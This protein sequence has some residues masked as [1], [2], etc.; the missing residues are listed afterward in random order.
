ML[1][2]ILRRVL[3][4]V[5]VIFAVVSCSFFLVR[6]MPGNPMQV[7]Y[8]QLSKQGGMTPLEIQQHIKTIY[9]IQ[10]HGSL[11]SQYLTYVGHAAQGDLGKSILDP[12]K[13]VVSVIANALPWT[14]LIVGTS[15]L[16]SFVIGVAAG[17]VMAAFAKRA[18]GKLV[19]MVSTIFSAI[20]NYL[21]ALILIYLLTDIHHVFPTSGPYSPSVAPG[22]TAPFI[23]SVAYHAILP[24]AAATVTAFGGWALAM[25][26]S[27]VSTLGSDYIRASESWGLTRRRITQSYIGR[28]SMLPVVTSLALS[29][30]GMFGGSVFIESLFS[31]PGLGYYL[32]QSVNSR[33]YSLMMG[34]FILITITVVLSNFVVDLLYP[35]VDPRIARAGGGGA[36]KAARRRAEAAEAEAEVQQGMAA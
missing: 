21:I 4:S 30:G 34:C 27:V 28:N 15:L 33:D 11:V 25:K 3:L 16:I 31:Y 10:P 22:F 23:G 36:A 24:V 20:P 32:I 2:Y 1:G 13:P 12:S 6:L 17:T 26:G 14:I 5:F 8:D 7:L 9:G 29:L 35:L 18:S 19:T